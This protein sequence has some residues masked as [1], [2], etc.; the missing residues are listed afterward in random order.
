MW[1]CCLEHRAFLRAFTTGCRG[2][3]TTHT[4]RG[5][6]RGFRRMDEGTPEAGAGDS[7]SA[8]PEE[9][10]PSWVKRGMISLWP[11]IVPPR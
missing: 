11:P 4:F 8:A 9:V 2:Q 7:V 5:I 6:C 10:E 1:S 3:S